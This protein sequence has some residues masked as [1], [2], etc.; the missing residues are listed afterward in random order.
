LGATQDSG[1]VSADAWASGFGEQF[2]ANV[3]AG[4]DD[5]AT[6]IAAALATVTAQD[7]LNWFAS[8]GYVFMVQD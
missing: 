7:A 6:A 2:Q 3:G 4:R 1:L 5:G 8:C